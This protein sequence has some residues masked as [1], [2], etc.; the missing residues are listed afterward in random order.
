MIHHYYR[1][2]HAVVFVYDVTNTA[3]FEVGSFSIIWILKFNFE[4]MHSNVCWIQ[5]LSQWIEECDGHNLTVLI[6]R[7]LVGN[8]FD[9]K[10]NQTVNTNRAQM[11]ADM[12]NMPVSISL[13]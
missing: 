13:L 10:E 11:F 7:I 2:V 5:A 3:S 4:E 1:N 8:K 9:C 12:H 6:P